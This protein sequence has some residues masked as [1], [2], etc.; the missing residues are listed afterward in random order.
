MGK[1]CSLHLNLFLRNHTDQATI[2]N[3]SSLADSFRITLTKSET[4]LSLRYRLRSHE[5]F[6]NHTDLRA[7]QLQWAWKESPGAI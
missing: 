1:L 7:S 4:D 5:N 3:T 2:A 6:G